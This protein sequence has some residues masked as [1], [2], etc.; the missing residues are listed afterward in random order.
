MLSEKRW[1]FFVWP[2]AIWFNFIVSLIAALIYVFIV[3]GP[4]PLNPQNT[5]W[6]LYDGSTYFIGWE[7]LRQDPHLHW[8]LTFTERIGYPVGT[9]T[10]LMDI[11]PLL[12]LIFKPMSPLL[13]TPF[14]YLGLAAALSCTLQI[15]FSL[16]LFRFLVGSD[17]FAV[18]LPSV[19]VLIAPPLNLRLG[20][21]FALTNQWLIVACL[22]LLIKT[23]HCP[24]VHLSWF[25]RFALVLVFIAAAINP[26]LAFLVLAVLTAAVVSL[27]WQGRLRWAGSVGI[28]LGLVIT[29]GL[30]SA[31]VGLP[32]RGA[33]AYSGN[34]G[35]RLYSMNL[36]AP[37][38]P[39]PF[40]SILIPQLPQLADGQLEGYNYL[41]LGVL[42]LGAISLPYLVFR[43]QNL[44]L[45][46]SQLVPLAVCC[47]VLALM[48]L[49]T[50]ISFG[51]RILCDLDPAEH[52]TKFLA[53][54]R[55]SGRFFWVPYYAVLT[56]ILASTFLIFR[57]SFATALVIF[58]LIIQIAD[59]SS[60]RNWVHSQTSLDFHPTPLRS[61]IWSSI[62]VHHQNLI[63]IPAWE[64]D[65]ANTPGGRDGFRIFGF[66]A[67]A[68][69]MRTNDY[70]A[71]RISPT[72][73]RYLCGDSL[74]D[75]LRKPLLPNTAYVVNATSAALI[76]AGPSGPGSCHNVD[77]F[78]LCSSTTD[79]GLPASDESSLPKMSA[80]NSFVFRDEPNP[81][82]FLPAGWYFEPRAAWTWSN[83]HGIFAF[84]LSR[85]QQ[86]AYKRL[87]LH[88]KAL[89]GHETLR[90]SVLSTTSRIDGS[91]PAESAPTIVD[92][93]V[94]VPLKSGPVQAFEI[95]TRNPPRP[96]DLGINSDSRDIG[97]GLVD[98]LLKP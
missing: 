43:R 2:D 8:P 55:A 35:Y 41:G 90:Y 9:S 62:G 54:L 16:R 79:F 5:S 48:A 93:K 30:V 33:S 21:H 74:L 12:A 52:L 45:R 69:R 3:M 51:S 70:F 77:G 89:V 24:Q 10:A 50:K 81:G 27:L 58:T 66:L 61:P 92:I 59:T 84:A 60:I 95:I 57:R 28:M 76:A 68:Q 87:A 38:S 73:L 72:D 91:A 63:V 78:I 6:L 36:L 7:M 4:K 23:V 44:G 19:F 53:P 1:P 39:T 13:P 49:S 29:C 47:V 17:P 40:R 98:A 64:C 96:V 67:V 86:L 15:F 80:S 32:L 83:G 56:A 37:I 34:T 11:I 65:S 18:V 82:K 46:A 75:L 71:P 42:I 85:E 94:E 26:Y 20:A 31:A 25:N 22:Y 97:V 14:Q 88:L